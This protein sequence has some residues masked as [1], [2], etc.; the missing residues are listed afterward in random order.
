MLNDE[1]KKTIQQAYR[2]LLENKSLKPRYG[3]KLMIAEIARTLG[4]IESD[5]DGNRITEGHVCVV[6]AGTGTGKTVAYTLSTLPVAKA[7]GKKVVISTATVALQEQVVYKDLPDILRHSDFKFTYALAKGRGR[8]LCL[9]KLDRQLSDDEAVANM[10]LYED[11]LSYKLADDTRELYQG[12]LDKLG[13][14]DWD[15]DRDNWVDAIDDTNWRGV[16][17]NHLEC[18]GRRCSNYEQCCFYNA[19]KSIHGVDV[20][21]ANHDLVLS[22]L[23]LGGG[24]V[25]PDPKDV[26]FVFDEGHHLPDKAI[27]HFAHY[28]RIKGTDKWLTQVEKNLGKM[29]SQMGAPG[30]LGAVIEEVPAITRQLSE[31]MVAL[32]GLLGQLVDF[33]QSSNSV[34]ANSPQHRF[35]HGQVPD[36]LKSFAHNLQVGFSRLTDSL[37]KIVN[38]LKDALS[39]D[40]TGIAKHDAETWYPI[41]GVLASR[42]TAG[43]EL[44]ST[45]AASDPAG[46]PPRARWLTQIEAGNDYDIEACASP[47]LSARALQ[48]CL[49]DNCYGAV[50][51]SATLTALGRF[52]RFMMRSGVPVES[53]FN[54]MPSPFDFANSAVFEVPTLACDPSNTESHTAAL[55]EYI[56]NEIA[57][58]IGALVLFTSN[59]QMND[60]LFGLSP[61]KR[62]EIIAQGDYSKQEMIRMHKQRIDKKQNS[63]LF[64]LSSLSEGIDLPGKYLEHVIL[65]K[66]PFAVPDD[67]VEATLSE[68]MENQGRNPFMEISVP[69]ASVRLIQAAGRLLRTET[70]TGKVSLLDRR[71][72][73]RRYGKALLD[74]LPP[75]TR[76]IA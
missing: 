50:V 64:G 66:L 28:G 19:R 51:T 17:T 25:L 5:D 27:S 70:D 44:W 57:E 30:T 72:V 61:E 55:V 15:G 39:D 16:T 62:K 65:A 38:E 53:T 13:S 60:V 46:E 31:Q 68:W 12:M 56:E 40:F 8:Y 20:I 48:A 42:A 4:N 26:I 22:D 34:H 6:E 41:I 10:A 37:E 21:V 49:W 3:Q 9:S 2:T 75:F 18:T 24:V 67:P 36:E 63:I 35:Q 74:A 14:N 76:K 7:H 23:A 52:E 45:Y 1:T 59:K 71:V 47:I 54:V 58:K 32:D 73:T 33:E 69:D 43:F 11:E 29:V